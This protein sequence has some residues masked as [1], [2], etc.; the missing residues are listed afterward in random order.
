MFAD[1]KL[2]LLFDARFQIRFLYKGWKRC[3][4]LKVYN[5]KY[6]KIVVLAKYA[7]YM[8]TVEAAILRAEVNF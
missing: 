7:I 4:V 1:S 8:D 3:Y 5:V 6:L 2:Q